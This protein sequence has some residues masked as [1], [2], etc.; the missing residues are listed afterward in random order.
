MAKKKIREECNQGDPDQKLQ[1]D[2]GKKELPDLMIGGHPVWAFLSHVFG[3]G[4]SLVP[5]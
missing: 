1:C 3:Y 2:R 5:F 4:S